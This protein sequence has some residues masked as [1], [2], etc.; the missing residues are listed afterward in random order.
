MGTLFSHPIPLQINELYYF[1]LAIGIFEKMVHD[2]TQSNPGSDQQLR[3]AEIL[4]LSGRQKI[5]LLD[6]HRRFPLLFLTNHAIFH[7]VVWTCCGLLTSLHYHLLRGI[8]SILSTIGQMNYFSGSLVFNSV[9][10]AFNSCH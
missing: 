4:N 2:A 1:H 3:T 10:R 8:Q 6:R 7:L 5:L 9:T